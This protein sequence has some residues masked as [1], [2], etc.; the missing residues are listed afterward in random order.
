MQLSSATYRNVDARRARFDVRAS[1]G[2][3]H[4]T[5]VTGRT[6]V[7]EMK[8]ASHAVQIVREEGAGDALAGSVCRCSS[9]CCC[10]D[11]FLVVGRPSFDFH[12][13]AGV[14]EVFAARRRGRN[15]GLLRRRSQHLAV[16]AR[17]DAFFFLLQ[18]KKKVIPVGCCRWDLS[19]PRGLVDLLR[20]RHGVGVVHGRA[21]GIDI[22]VVGLVVLERRDRRD[23][24]R[25]DSRSLEGGGCLSGQERGGKI[26]AHAQEEVNGAH[27]HRR[28]EQMTLHN[29]QQ[30]EEI[31]QLRTS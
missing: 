6:D 4:A 18:K 8:G 20:R 15:D 24:E 17:S 23:H 27:R 22:M 7:A 5:V 9:C 28:A 12:D 16:E 10:H 21:V 30:Q 2:C 3:Q 11:C 14:E 25:P 19:V 29:P 1:I 13:V 31:H 26:S